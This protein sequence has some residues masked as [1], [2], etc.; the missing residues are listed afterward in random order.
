MRKITN[1]NT[2][3]I[4]GIDAL[5]YF[6]QSGGGY[7]EFYMNIVDQI[8]DKKAEFKAFDYAYNDNDI[9][10]KINNIDIKYSGAGR[11]GFLWFNHE[12]FRVEFKDAEKSN[13]R[14]Q[15]NSIAIYTLDIKSL[16]EYINEEFL[17]G[18]LLNERYFP[19][20]RIDVNMFIQ[21][22]GDRENPGTVATL[23]PT[24]IGLFS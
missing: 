18:A 23:K 8:E 21:K 4:S 2:P 13:I 3:Q 1:K 11:D 16:V 5:Y 17:Q 9:I 6:A 15:L 12:F 10:I 22:S 7:D 14:V 24:K 19:V 20:T